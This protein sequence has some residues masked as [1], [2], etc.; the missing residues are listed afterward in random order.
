[1]QR[2]WKLPFLSSQIWQDWKPE[3]RELMESGGWLSSEIKAPR[4]PF[5]RDFQ[6]FPPETLSDTQNEK[7]KNNPLQ[8]CHREEIFWYRPR[9]I[10]S[11]K[12][13]TH[14]DYIY[15]QN[16]IGI[17]FRRPRP[18][19]WREIPSLRLHSLPEYPRERIRKICEI[20]SFT[21]IGD[22]TIALYVIFPTAEWSFY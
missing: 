6:T 7:Q 10:Y 4:E 15:H 14:R 19:Q 5:S 8:T 11:L 21:K 16:L 1:M 3:I 12:V 22:L 20:G 18:S 2:L 17:Y 13:Q 9:T